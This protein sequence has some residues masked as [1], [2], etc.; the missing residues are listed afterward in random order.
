[1]PGFEQNIVHSNRDSA[2]RELIE[3]H[4]INHA[5]LMRINHAQINS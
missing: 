3:L 1:M 4:L 2:L 5:Q